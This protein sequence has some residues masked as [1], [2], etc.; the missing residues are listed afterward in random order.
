MS[1]RWRIRVVLVA[2]AAGVLIFFGAAP[3][4]QPW[5]AGLF[6]A[7]VPVLSVAGRTTAAVRGWVIGAFAGRV[8]ALEE[9]RGRL[10]A[11][12]AEL[13]AARQE[14]ETL[15]AALA[16]RGEGEAGAIPA[17]AIAF[18]REGRDEFLVLNRGTADGIGIG[19]VVVN[20]N[21]VLGGTVVGVDVHS[22]RAILYSSPSRSIDVLVPA[23]R[24]RAIARGSNARELS[25]E[26]VPPDAPLKAGDLLL[27]SPRAT[28]G[29][30]PL[31]LGEVREVRQA[32]HE[33]FKAVRATHLFD[34][35]DTEVIVLLAP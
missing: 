3:A 22:A 7:V 17:Q 8:G 25:I 27:A 30:R 5:R 6:G 11:R 33:V 15:R 16:L 35:A 31:L 28:G 20:T 12:L 19:D 24:L 13:E 23:I 4:L 2:A 9:E 14:N 10:L 34:P 29:R 18:L 21:R 1:R 26:L 32:E